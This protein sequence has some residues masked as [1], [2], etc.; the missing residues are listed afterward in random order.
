MLA[1]LIPLPVA[2]LAASLMLVVFAETAAAGPFEDAVSAYGRGDYATAARLFRP[3]AEKS[4]TDAQVML[5]VMYEQGR[6]VPRDYAQAYKWYN[7]AASRTSASE[8][9]ERDV[10][11][12]SRDLVAAFLTP[13]QIAEAHQEMREW[14]PSDRPTANLRHLSRVPRA[15]P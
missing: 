15:A 13:A 1:R 2:A 9:E 6:G 14:R 8:K 3:L 4:D 7:L 10:V 11:V 5:G 12:K